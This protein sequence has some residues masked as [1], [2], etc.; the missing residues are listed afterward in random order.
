MQ[1]VAFYG[2]GLVIAWF[3]TLYPPVQLHLYDKTGLLGGRA[4]GAQDYVV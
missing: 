1:V 4:S 2:A 3:V